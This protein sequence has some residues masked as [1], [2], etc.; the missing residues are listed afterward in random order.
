M[1]E[2]KSHRLLRLREYMAEQ[3]LDGFLVSSAANRRYVSGFTGSN[4]YLVITATES[5]LAT[6]FRY[7]EQ[8]QSESPI[9]EVC[10]IRGESP[11]FQMSSKSWK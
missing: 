2:N 10:H 9:F 7:I 1:T 6:D 8:A 5:V 11:G 3:D 4:G